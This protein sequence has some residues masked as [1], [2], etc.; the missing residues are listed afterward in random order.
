MITKGP[1]KGESCNLPTFNETKLCST[2]RG[3]LGKS[4]ALER[5]VDFL[6]RKVKSLNQLLTRWMSKKPAQKL[7]LNNIS[8]SPLKKLSHTDKF[9]FI[10]IQPP[11]KVTVKCGDKTLVLKVPKSLLKLNLT[12]ENYLKFN[13]QTNKFKWY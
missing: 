8:F 4:T 9:H 11:N 12:E 7:K 13:E 3:T 6:E 10:A 1:R 2:H 5:R